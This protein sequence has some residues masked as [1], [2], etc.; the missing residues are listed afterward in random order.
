[1]DTLIEQTLNFIKKHFKDDTSGHDYYHSF[2]V[3]QLATKIA[4]YEN[5]DLFTVQM[6][7][8]LHDVD[9]RKLSQHSETLT[10]TR[11]FLNTLDIT[12]TQID[13]IC[14]IISEISYK[15]TD[16]L[17]PSTIEGKIV[18]DA[19]RIDA[20]GAIGIARAFTY[21]GS[22]HRN[23][24]VPDCLPLDNMCAKDYYKNSSSTINHFHEKLLK[25]YNLMNTKNGKLLA[26]HRYHYI[27]SFLLEFY[28]EWDC[29]L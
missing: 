21:G 24:Y 8:L 16:T 3:Y 7:A 27:K 19:D 25:L 28:K 29:K 22:I 17:I 2:R 18:Q 10:T 15:G 1:M 4:T 6:A 14:K 13:T 12:D 9:D 20:L 5:C 26:K 11:N 23:I